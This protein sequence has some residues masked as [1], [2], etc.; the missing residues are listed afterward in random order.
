MALIDSRAAL[1]A[2][3]EVINKTGVNQWVSVWQCFDH[4][5]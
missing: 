3:D 4:R 1:D 5:R 2:E